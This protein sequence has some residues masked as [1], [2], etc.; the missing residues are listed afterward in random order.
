[1]ANFKNKHPN[2]VHYFTV[3]NKL[4]NEEE[5]LTR[6]IEKGIYNAAI[7][8]ARDKGII[9]SWN[10]KSFCD[11]Y[12]NIAQNVVINLDPE[13]H[14]GNN[15]LLLSRIISGEVSG[16]AL[17]TMNP[18]DL[19]PERWRAEI[20]NKELKEKIAQ[21][22]SNPK[23]NTDGFKCYKCKSTSLMFNT[24]QLRSAD[25]GMNTLV[26]CNNCGNKFTM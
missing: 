19:F 12:N 5:Q 6:E 4:V 7:D 16:T 18:E 20:E 26:T 23:K 8:L 17:A 24:V 3:I 9:R 22:A 14:I 21:E 25:E 2:R 15:G 1:M 10:N 11:V 13:S